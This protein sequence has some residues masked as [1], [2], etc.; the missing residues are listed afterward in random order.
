E[1]VIELGDNVFYNCY[2]LKTF[3]ATGSLVEMGNGVFGT[4][5]S[6]ASSLTT[7]IL[8]ATLKTIGEKTFLNCDKLTSVTFGDNSQLE[9]LPANTFYGCVALQSFEIPQ[10][11]TVLEGRDPEY[12][13]VNEDN[14]GL[15]YGLTSLKKVT[16]APNSKCTEIGY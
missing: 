14:T 16:F 1:S 7:V 10:N 4:T 3:T 8:P 6:G 15:F 12:T 2:Q 13:S 11:I 9:V 5:S